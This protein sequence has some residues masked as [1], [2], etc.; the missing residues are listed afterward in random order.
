MFLASLLLLMACIGR[1][2]LK[3]RAAMK[4]GVSIEDDDFLVDDN[5]DEEEELIGWDK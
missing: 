3:T 5:D 2:I 1:L 4:V